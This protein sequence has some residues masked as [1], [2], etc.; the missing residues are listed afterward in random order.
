MV[1]FNCSCLLCTR[2]FFSTCFSVN[3]LN[4]PVREGIVYINPL[5][6]IPEFFLG[7]ISAKLFLQYQ[8]YLLSLF[9]SRR[10]YKSVFFITLLDFI[11]LFLLLLVLSLCLRFCRYLKNDAKPVVV[12][13]VFFFWYLSYFVFK[14]FPFQAFVLK[15]INFSGRD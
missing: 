2:V 6:R 11:A 15:A 1:V 3:H 14:G 10:L 7:I 9:S 13:F 12:C 5:F 8:P 4:M